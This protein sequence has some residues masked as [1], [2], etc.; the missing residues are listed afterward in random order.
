[1]LYSAL[2]LWNTDKNCNAF[3]IFF[4]GMKRR[5]VKLW[6]QVGPVSH[7][8]MDVVSVSGVSKSS[9][10]KTVHLLHHAVRHTYPLNW[11]TLRTR[12][13]V[14]ERPTAACGG[15]VLRFVMCRSLISKA[16]QN[17]QW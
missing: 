14:Y 15:V 17:G 13:R 2:W 11:L 4:K 10:S 6:E 3:C 5:P 12:A 7:A 9:E 8:S 16:H 1:M